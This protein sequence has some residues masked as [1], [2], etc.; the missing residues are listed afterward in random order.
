MHQE[1]IIDDENLLNEKCKQL[2][3]A[4]LKS[5]FCVVYTGAGLSTSANIPD[6]RGPNGNYRLCLY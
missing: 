6:Y 1:I 2:A 3:D 4:I 5:K